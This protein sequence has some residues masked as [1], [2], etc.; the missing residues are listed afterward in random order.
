[1]MKGGSS[2]H[3]LGQGICKSLE[4]IIN[5]PEYL[6]PEKNVCQMNIHPK[7]RLKTIRRSYKACSSPKLVPSGKRLH[8]YGK[9]QFSMGQFTLSMVIFNSYVKLF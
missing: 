5:P 9:S 7:K 2:A 6:N 8:N 1:M 4:T 3:T